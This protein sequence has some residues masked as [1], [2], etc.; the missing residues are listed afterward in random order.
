MLRAASFWQVHLDLSFRQDTL[1]DR[2][3]R[4]RMEQ[5][6]EP[7]VTEQEGVGGADYSL[8]HLCGLTSH[9]VDQIKT[10]L[11]ILRPQQNRPD[12]DVGV[13]ILKAA[14]C[15]YCCLFFTSQLCVCTVKK[16]QKWEQFPFRM[17]APTLFYPLMD[18]TLWRRESANDVLQITPTHTVQVSD[19]LCLC[20]TNNKEELWLHF[21]ISG[22]FQIDKSTLE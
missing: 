17:T 5:N 16:L 13:R 4:C 7:G 14:Q 10:E 2:T 15:A 1:A 19:F 6:G 21:L 12:L 3:A 11:T 8:L 20:K 18:R 9:C 22:G